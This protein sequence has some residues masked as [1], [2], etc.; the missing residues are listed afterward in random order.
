M[1]A[2]AVITL[3]TIV[4]V[5]SVQTFD[6]LA[7]HAGGPVAIIL[8]L[9]A[10]FDGVATSPGAPEFWWVYAMLLSTMIPSL[11]NLMIG[12]ASLLRGVPWLTNALLRAMP[13]ERAPRS[14]DRTW[15]ALL[16]TSQVFLG[17]LL[18]IAA[19]GVLVY[20]L[21]G[22]ALPWFGWDL[23]G[24]ARAVAAPDWPGQAIAWL[25]GG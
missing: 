4:S 5:L 13:A 24:V 3:L 17:G 1:A 12:G 14:F 9:D 8:P 20:V 7:A 22:L 6:D 2:A 18:G 25:L 21:I 15:I 16:L 11:L 19:Q 23:L 10:L